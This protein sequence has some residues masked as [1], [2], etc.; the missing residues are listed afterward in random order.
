MRRLLFLIFLIIGILISN[1][2]NGNCE[3]KDKACD[4]KC[5]EKCKEK[6]S[7]CKDKESSNKEK[8]KCQTYKD[9][10]K[11]FFP[12]YSYKYN[13]QTGEKSTFLIPLLSG[14]YENYTGK[15]KTYFKTIYSIPILF[16]MV[17]ANGANM[18]GQPFGR[19]IAWI[20][21]F[22]YYT[23]WKYENMNGTILSALICLTS[24]T[25]LNECKHFALLPLPFISPFVE[26][27]KYCA[28]DV[29]NYLQKTDKEDE[30]WNK[31]TGLA[32]GFLPIHNI[33]GLEYISLMKEEG[34]N[35]LKEKE[36]YRL[37][38]I[39]YPFISNYKS[40]NRK[41]T[42]VL[43]L[44]TYSKEDGSRNFTLIPLFIGW[45]S[46]KGIV[47]EPKAILKWWPLIN[48]DNYL[49]KADFLWPLGD[50]EKKGNLQKTVN[51]D[52]LYEHFKS[53]ERTTHSFGPF[54]ILGDYKRTENTTKS[55]ILLLLF[56]Y[57]EKKDTIRKYSSLF[58][59]FYFSKKWGEE[60]S[61]TKSIF[62][63]FTYQKTELKAEPAKGK[64][65][66]IV[67]P[68]LTKFG[69]DDKEKFIR[70]LFLFKIS[71]KR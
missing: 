17:E 27:Q 65:S 62:P 4:C 37:S 20:P 35:Y 23:H 19:I 6:E 31:M 67:W 45:K 46:D 30:N 66:I 59:I 26:Y 29:L 33:T 52:L 60:I 50:Y 24:Y 64:K 61:S 71:K 5:S 41:R 10:H 43:P 22:T 44:F 38:S 69:K 15:D 47:L 18:P 39:F 1:L 16:F 3:S 9:I 12:L 55:N 42:E 28:E 11:T 32:Q 40:E 53:K 57:Y 51:I 13:E 34:R 70:P 14:S 7:K 25:S 58:P 63:L 54:S 8:C 68:L 48:Y 56:N 36:D 2:S 49:D 21:T